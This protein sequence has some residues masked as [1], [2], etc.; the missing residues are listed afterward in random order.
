MRIVT[1]G[2]MPSLREASCCKVEVVKGGKGWRLPGFASIE[3]TLKL[4]LSSASLKASASR[5]PSPC[6]SRSAFTRA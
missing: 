4:A 2:D 6:A 1:A 3:A 5:L